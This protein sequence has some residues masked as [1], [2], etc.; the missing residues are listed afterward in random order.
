VLGENDGLYTF[1]PFKKVVIEEE[2][3]GEK[4]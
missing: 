4:L 3:K 1:K 2:E